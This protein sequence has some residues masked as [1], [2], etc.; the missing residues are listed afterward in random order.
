MIHMKYLIIIFQ[1]FL[2]TNLFSQDCFVGKYLDS[3]NT[4]TYYSLDINS[5]NT[6]L[7][8]YYNYGKAIEHK[9]EWH[10]RSPKNFFLRK[11]KLHLLL[12][13]KERGINAK[14]KYIW[15]AKYKCQRGLMILERRNLFK[16]RIVFRKVRTNSV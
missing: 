8:T 15:N 16:K 9:G 6:F 12:Y 7:Y 13:G 5:D 3:T 4:V 2:I 10:S 1:I 11:N 14:V